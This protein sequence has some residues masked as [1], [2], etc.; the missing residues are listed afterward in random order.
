M[1]IQLG[2]IQVLRNAGRGW[3]VSHFPGKSISKVYSS[4]A[5][6]LRGVGGGQIS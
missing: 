1:S 5:L 3:G 2:A 4:M 6:A